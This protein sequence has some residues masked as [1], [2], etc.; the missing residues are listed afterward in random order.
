MRKEILKKVVLSRTETI[1][2]DKDIHPV[3]SLFKMASYYHN[4]FIS[5][6]YLPSKILWITATPELLVEIDDAN[7]FKTVALAGTQTPND[8]ITTKTLWTAKN[9]EEQDIVSELYCECLAILR[10]YRL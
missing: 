4:A 3:E 9:K 1:E 6:C 2:F 5:L 7:T 8:H 10:Y